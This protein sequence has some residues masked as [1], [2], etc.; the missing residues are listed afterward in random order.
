MGSTEFIGVSTYEKH[1]AKEPLLLQDHH[2]LVCYRNS[3]IREL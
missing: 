2:N 1:A 3:W